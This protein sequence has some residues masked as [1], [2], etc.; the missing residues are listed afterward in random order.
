MRIRK[1]TVKILWKRGIVRT[2]RMVVQQDDALLVDGILFRCTS[3][4]IQKRSERMIVAGMLKQCD[5]PLFYRCCHPAR[6]DVGISQ[7]SNRAR[8]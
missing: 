4:K 5:W 3:L 1:L 6:S 8:N 7:T 2:M